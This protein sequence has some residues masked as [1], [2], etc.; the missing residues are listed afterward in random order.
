MKEF[1]DMINTIQLGD[2]YE[3]IKKIPDKSIDLIIID[4]PYKFST[5]G[6]QGIGSVRKVFDEI[7]EQKLNI[8]IDEKIFEELKRV[9]KEF[10]IYIWCNKTMIPIM[11]QLKRT[12]NY[13]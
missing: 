5:L 13:Q 12:M 11:I 6:G 10:N 7:E 8:G 1:E 3:L 9:M 4:P 2:C